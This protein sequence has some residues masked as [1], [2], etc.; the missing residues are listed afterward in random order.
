M[1]NLLSLALGLLSWGF[2]CAAIGRRGG[3]GLC[4]GS[5]TLCSAALWLQ[6]KELQNVIILRDDYAAAC[7]TID[8]VVFAAAVL[9]VVTV[10]LNGIALLRR[11][12][13]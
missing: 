2:A 7:D 11:R 3:Y 6:L 10:A 4:F 5:M 13:R 12:K 9:V 1:N 8:A